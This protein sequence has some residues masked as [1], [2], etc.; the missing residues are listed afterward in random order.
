MIAAVG[1]S[2]A[3]ALVSKI[4]N[5]VVAMANRCPSA[6]MMPT[7]T[8]GSRMSDSRW[9]SWS[10]WPCAIFLRVQVGDVGLSMSADDTVPVLDAL[11][12]LLASAASAEGVA[13]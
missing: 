7:E 5:P 6:G 12:A 4:Q 8:Y 1:V 10:A 13:R 9:V 3:T 2:S 11:S